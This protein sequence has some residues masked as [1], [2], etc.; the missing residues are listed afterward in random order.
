MKAYAGALRELG[1][2]VIE[3]ALTRRAGRVSEEEEDL[4]G[5]LVNESTRPVTWLGMS[6]QPKHPEVSADT[7]RRLEPIIRRGGVPQ[8]LP[9]AVRGADEHA[10]SVHL[11]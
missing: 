9:E 2:G 8:V 3:V 6:S 5:F 1:K 11:R 4:L 10:R 7:M